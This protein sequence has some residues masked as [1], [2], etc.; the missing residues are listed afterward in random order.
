MAPG[1]TPPQ[2]EALAPSPERAHF[3]LLDEESGRRSKRPADALLLLAA[4]ALAVL[5]ALIADAKDGSEP[6]ALHSFAQLFGWFDT[7]WQIIYLATLA[8]GV[9]VFLEAVVLRRWHLV[10]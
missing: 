8:F 2:S 1:Q 9:A 7:G 6:T 3:L 4:G 5:G 10:R